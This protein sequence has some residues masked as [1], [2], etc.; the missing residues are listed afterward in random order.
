MAGPGRPKG[1]QKY[2]GRKK[3]TPNKVTAS[4]KDAIMGAFDAKGGQQYLERVAE[5]DPKT[6]CT[7]LGKVL[8]AEVKADIQTDGEIRVRWMS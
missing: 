6:F 4:L 2:G 1:G 3:G 5:D 8:P 7:L